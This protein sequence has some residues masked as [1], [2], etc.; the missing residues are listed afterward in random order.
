MTVMVRPHRRQVRLNKG[1]DEDAAGTTF[2]EADRLHNA[3]DFYTSKNGIK[4][5]QDRN[6]TRQGADRRDRRT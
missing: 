3:R 5:C 4:S 1:G 2:E 6:E